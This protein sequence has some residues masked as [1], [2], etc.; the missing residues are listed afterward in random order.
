MKKSTLLARALT[1]VMLLGLLLGLL[2]G[3]GDTAAPDN[4]NQQTGGGQTISGDMK[5]GLS[6]QTMGAPYFVSQ[7]KAFEAACQVQGI[8]VV[9]VDAGGDMTKQQSDIEDLVSQGCNVIVINPAD[10]QGAVAIANSVMEQGIPVFI[11]DNSID[12]SAQYISMIQSNNFAIGTLVGEWLVRKFGNEE[13]RIGMLSGNEGNLLGVDRRIGVVKGLVEAQL[14]SS[15]RTNFR[16]LT[17]GWGGWNQ[18]DGLAAA[19]SMLTAAPDINVIVAENDSMGLGAVIALENAG[20]SDVVVVGIDGQKEALALVQSGQYGASGL[21][22]P[23]GV[24]NLTLDTI[25]RYKNGDKN[26]Q[27]LIN[28]EPA[29]ITSDNVAQYYNPN[30]DF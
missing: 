14:A 18:E 27:K 13:I 8:S 25:I 21:N 11:M 12:P 2:T 23:V 4:G 10:A 28:T 30:S 24:A 19:E 5:I 26:I 20:R 16:F 17:Q 22:D 15:N 1:A 9:S 7:S 29:V 3:C 6:M